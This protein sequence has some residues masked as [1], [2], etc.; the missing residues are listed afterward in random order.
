M[1]RENG[2]GLAGTIVQGG[3][4]EGRNEAEPV[5]GLWLHPLPSIHVDRPGNLCKFYLL[6]CT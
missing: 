5:H 4:S 6:I 2:G 1:K 3:R